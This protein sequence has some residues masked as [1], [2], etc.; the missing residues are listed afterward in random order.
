M[1]GV[2]LHCGLI[3]F[4]QGSGHSV[5]MQQWQSFKLEYQL[6]ETEVTHFTIIT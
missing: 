5:L 4:C 6:S 2:F 3:M 1:Q